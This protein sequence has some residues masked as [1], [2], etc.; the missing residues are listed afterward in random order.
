MLSET[1]GE[2]LGEWDELGGPIEGIRRHSTEGTLGDRSQPTAH[3][4]SSEEDGG[5]ES[6]K[7]G[8]AH[9]WRHTVVSGF[10]GDR[11]HQTQTGP[12]NYQHGQQQRCVALPISPVSLASRITHT[13]PADLTGSHDLAR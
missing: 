5:T 12:E 11:V 6:D 8:S 2:R 9:L 13:N 4:G 1:Y 7:E 3:A 10:V